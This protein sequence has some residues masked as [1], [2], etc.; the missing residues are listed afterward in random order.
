MYEFDDRVRYSET[1]EN[2]E[3]K[4]VSM[5]NYLQDCSTF[6]SN[7]VGLSME[8][9]AEMKRAWLLSYWDIYIDRLP[10][11]CE[12]ITIGT[13]PYA[14]RGVIAKR[15]FWIKDGEGKYL[16][17]ADSQWFAFDPERMRPAKIDD[18]ILKPFGKMENVLGLP[19]SS[20]KI[21]LP[22]E[23]TALPEIVAQK[24]HIDSNHHVNNAQYIEMASESLYRYFPDANR[25]K[26]GRIR[27]EYQK[28]A[29]LNDVLYPKIGKRDDAI[30]V[31]LQSSTGDVFANVEI[32]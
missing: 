11:F 28:A 23:M 6:H 26:R 13:S 16:L 27:A 32:S 22:D 29:V 19:E 14:F 5:I 4:V 3:M 15:N 7:D 10:R 25:W 9:L 17:R 12:K 1:D 24:H 21:I 31:S 20:R 8:K 2:G 30:V 18:A